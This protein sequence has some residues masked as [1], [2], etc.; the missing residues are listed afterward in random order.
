MLTLCKTIPQTL[1]GVLSTASILKAILFGS[2]RNEETHELF[3]ERSP[4]KSVSCDGN[5]MGCLSNSS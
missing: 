2:Q 4:D 1:L 5:N 3:T